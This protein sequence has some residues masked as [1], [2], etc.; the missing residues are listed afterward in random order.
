MS[1]RIPTRSAGKSERLPVCLPSLLGPVLIAPTLC[2]GA[3]YNR[4]LYSLGGLVDEDVPEQLQ[5][6]GSPAPLLV[7][8]RRRQRPLC[9]LPRLGDA[10]ED[11]IGLGQERDEQ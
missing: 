8:A 5:S 2:N 1:G 3:L 10:S 7:G 6:P 11:E 9:V 4:A